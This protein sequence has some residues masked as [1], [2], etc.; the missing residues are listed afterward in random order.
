M[1]LI[2]LGCSVKND[3][4]TSRFYHSNTSKYNILYNGELLYQKAILEL[5]NN[6]EDVFWEK[7]PL[8]KIKVKK[9]QSFT[10]RLLTYKEKR[11]S[12]LKE[13]GEK[14]EIDSLDANQ[15]N[16]E[17]AEDKAVKAIQKHSMNIGY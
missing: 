17:K 12:F 6:S 14:Q 13:E 15:T 9:S 3:A 16:F 5:E 2:F 10:D 4:L 7:L 11:R 8:E 1:C